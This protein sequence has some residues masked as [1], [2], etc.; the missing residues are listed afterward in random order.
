[1]SVPYLTYKIIMKD[2]KNNNYRLGIVRTTGEVICIKQAMRGKSCDCICPECGKPFIAAQGEIY[3]WYFKHLNEKTN[4]SGG[5]EAA[6]H[7]L[8][9]T[10]ILE[11]CEI[12][13][14][15]R[16]VHRY[17]EAI[18]EKYFGT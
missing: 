7:K 13:L 4:C 11:N 6:I 12:N 14:G 15:K 17:N 1:M 3:E 8:S 16:G 5:Q 10:I 9:K 18:A 2:K